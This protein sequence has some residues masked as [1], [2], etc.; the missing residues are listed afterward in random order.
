MLYLLP[1]EV[2]SDPN[3]RDFG[4]TSPKG[5]M[6]LQALVDSNFMESP[7]NA[8]SA[9]RF[10]LYANT[11]QLMLSALYLGFNNVLTIMVMSHEYSSF[12]T[13]R[14]GLRVTA[15]TGAQLSSLRLNVPV[16]YALVNMSAW[17]VLHWLAS[18]ML[19]AQFTRTF[20]A[21]DLSGGFQA[22]MIVYVSRMGLLTFIGF[23][24]V[25]VTFTLL[26]GLRR[27]PKGIPLASTN[28]ATIAAACHPPADE[29]ENSAELPLMYGKR[30]Y[31][32]S[33]WIHCFSALPV[34]PITFDEDTKGG[35][36]GR[37]GWLSNLFGAKA[38]RVFQRKLL[39]SRTEE[40]DDHAVLLEDV[41][42]ERSWH[43]GDRS[44]VYCTERL[45]KG[46]VTSG[47]KCL[48]ITAVG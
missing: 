6:R 28:S 22:T 24:S 8:R 15:P 34:Q 43:G 2:P 12:A 25:V 23:G 45:W 19:S 42:T 40:D 4:D 48:S 21:Y 27:Y 46:N 17:A 13:K 36:K 11:P 41:R 26:L 35:L 9:I 20:S 37:L 30:Q 38:V 1:L 33:E 10:A 29:P 16:K 31:E 47:F 5:E 39:Q 44:L 14:Q 32:N 3:S 7:F 18:Q